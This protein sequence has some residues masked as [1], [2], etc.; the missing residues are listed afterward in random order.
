MKKNEIFL[1]ET[2]LSSSNANHIS[3][4]AK[5][6]ACELQ[7]EI[8]NIKFLNCKL[9][10][11]AGSK[12]E[13][14]NIETEKDVFNKIPFLLKRIGELNS[15]IAWLREGIKAKEDE[16]K[17]IPSNHYD[18]CA[19][20]G[21]KAPSIG[22]KLPMATEEDVIGEMSIKDRNRYYTLE[23][24]AAKIGSYIHPGEHFSKI[25]VE[26]KNKLRNPVETIGQGSEM[27]VKKYDSSYSI[28]EVDKMF[29]D[30]QQQHRD[31]QAELNGMKYSIN[32][33]VTKRNLEIG[34]TNKQ[35][36]LKYNN[37]IEDFEAE[38]DLFSKSETAR[39][40][41]L[42]IIIPNDLKEI[43]EFINKIGKKD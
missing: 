14:I 42:K 37:E 22:A 39:I 24:M 32:S 7:N 12:T 11:L 43:Y 35:T 41:S 36:A 25:R 9:S 18:Y 28:E 20:I 30:L 21:K 29:F 3:N 27:S 33:E 38:I 26:L 2:G 31:L 17:R 23:A 40:E 5:E 1:A 10:L 8:N 4:I 16:I 6:I 15:L 13:I 34:N 19:L